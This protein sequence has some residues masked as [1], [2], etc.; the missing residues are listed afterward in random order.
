MPQEVINER[1]WAILCYIPGFNIVSCPIAAV[2]MVN[3][4]L[5]SFHARQGL[6]LFLLWFAV[7]ILALISP[8][9]SLIV[10]FVMIA[11]HAWGFAQA[12][13]MGKSK[14]PVVGEIAMKIP[15]TFLFTTLTGKNPPNN[16]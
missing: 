14:L 11:L 3:S 16:S 10:F 2:R 4:Q 8:V 6:I 12:F 13:A 15:E 9:L 1:V 5:V 7:I